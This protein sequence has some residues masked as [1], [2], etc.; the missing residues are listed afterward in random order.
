VQGASESA[1]GSAGMVELAQGGLAARILTLGA[2]LQRLKVPDRDGRIANVTLGCDDEAGYL[3]QSTYLGAVIGRY[4]NRIAGGAF[5]LD[6]VR[7]Q[8]PLNN[9]PNN[10][11]GGPDGFDRAT[12]TLVERDAHSATL[13]LVSPAGEN[14]FPGILSAQIVYTLEADGL[15]IALSATTDAPTLA[16]LTHHAYW[17]LAGAG[18]GVP[19]TDHW[20]QIPASRYTPVDA[21]QIPTGELAPVAGTPFDFR[22]PKLIGRDID[23][24]DEQLRL[25]Q[26]YDHNLVIDGAD[27]SFRRVATL[28]DP[29][30]GRVLDLY[31]TAPG[32]QFYTGNHLA[33]GSSWPAR[34]G[35]ALEPQFFPDSPNQPGFPS[36][37]LDPGARYVHN[38]AFR[39]RTATS[40]ESAFPA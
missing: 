31:S 10:L 18:S 8:L 37:R 1:G 24:D 7:Y 30:S 9:G 19:V 32:L 12:W 21:T 34:S 3:A 36:A 20:L 38:L 35:M 6:G 16:N 17:N 15:S 26:G 40:L 22:T 33:G 25:G 13:S 29:G 2:I 28:Y 14:G 27:G 4:A 39:F 23:V 5:T 11:H